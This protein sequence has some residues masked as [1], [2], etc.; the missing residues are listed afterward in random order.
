MQQSKDDLTRTGENAVGRRGFLGLAGLGG[1][2][3]LLAWSDSLQAS[4]GPKAIRP[5]SRVRRSHGS[6]Y[7]RM[8]GV[9]AIINA[10]GPVTSLGGTLLS[11]EVTDAM[12]AASRDFVDL[13]ELYTAAGVRLAQITKSEAAMV[14]SGA[15][16]AM[17]LG[18]AACLAGND[19]G[20]M[21][22]LPFP[23][24]AV[25]ETIIQRAHST[26]YDQAYRDAGM[27]IVYVDTED[28][29]RAAISDPHRHD[30]G[31]AST[32]RE[33]GSCRAFIPLKQLVVIGKNAGVPVY[34][35][36][37]FLR[38]PHNSPPSSLWRYTTDG[39]RHRRHQRR[40]GAPRSA[41]HRHLGGTR[42]SHRRR[43][44]D[45]VAERSRPWPRHE[46]R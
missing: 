32:H 31:P 20:S 17:T 1:A 28:Q 10:A 40:Q 4:P 36:A 30:R 7:E 24:C 19:K 8:F 11:K 35:D 45:G 34:F 26:A 21:A 44:Q 16:A 15:S 12:A 2:A 43:A 38:N 33:D 46:G 22:A 6:V 5:R 42:R 27:T 9:R 23:T 3:P 25:P 14:T 18:A 41:G 29:M 39:S 13:N 37:S